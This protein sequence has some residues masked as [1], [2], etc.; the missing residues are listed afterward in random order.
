MSNKQMRRRRENGDARPFSDPSMIRPDRIEAAPE[1][2]HHTLD[3][4]FNRIAVMQAAIAL[5]RSKARA[6]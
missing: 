6:S 2:I 5:L 1:S 3:V 4:Q